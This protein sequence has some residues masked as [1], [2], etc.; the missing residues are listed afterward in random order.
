M[1]DD[2]DITMSYQDYNSTASTEY[3]AIIAS[4]DEWRD[5]CGKVGEAMRALSGP[6]AALPSQLSDLRASFGA[7]QSFFKAFASG[8][9]AYRQRI[10]GFK[11]FYRQPAA[12]VAA[13]AQKTGK[14]GWFGARREVAQ[15]VQIEPRDDEQ[16]VYEGQR[17]FAEAKRRASEY[18]HH[19]EAVKADV[20]KVIAETE[21][22]GYALRAAVVEINDDLRKTASR[23]LE[24]RRFQLEDAVAACSERVVQLGLNVRILARLASA[25]FLENPF[26]A[27]DAFA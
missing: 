1:E 15:A 18:D 27:E 6:D 17:A 9:E 26:V 7:E 20:E 19:L 25:E 16:G 13:V 14:T 22:V 24:T 23:K 5:L 3:G 4:T 8:A 21:E 2:Q 12:S 10:D 11:R